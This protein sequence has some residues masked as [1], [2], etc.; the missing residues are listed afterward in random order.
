[1]TDEEVSPGSVFKYDVALS[2]L[3][4]D[5]SL[6]I[7]LADRLR[8]RM[9]VFVYS[10]RQKELAGRD[11]MDEFTEIF[12]TKV[13]VCVVLYREGWGRTKWTAI[14]ETAIKNRAFDCGWDFLLVI[15]LNTCTGPIWL[16]RTKLWL[17]FKR[18]GLDGAEAVIDVKVLESGGGGREES[19]TDMAER[20][21][22]QAKIKEEQKKFLS[23]K[24]GV[25]YAQDA[26]QEMFRILERRISELLPK[27]PLN[28]K[29]T[30]GSD[31]Y[32]D[33]QLRDGRVGVVFFWQQHSL[34]TVEG[35]HLSIN[36]YSAGYPRPK[37][38]EILMTFALDDSGN[39]T[40]AEKKDPKRTYSS[41]EF[42]DC[43]LKRLLTE[44][45]EGKTALRPY[46]LKIE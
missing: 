15:P 3:A 21:I 25:Q 23:S 34:V 46:R 27:V 35:S 39:P 38:R 37:Q 19:P 17:D 20:L 41:E 16:P 14:E 45:Y 33:I 6:A 44:I 2:F 29:T 10:E 32:R 43:F 40:W 12:R 24:E 31:A 11:G 9:E 30:P 8:D 26:I 7:S 42:V 13:R 1:M 18:F 22:R 36:E 5:E 28:L 4:E